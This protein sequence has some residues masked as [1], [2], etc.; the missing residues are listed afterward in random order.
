MSNSRSTIDYTEVRL[1]VHLLGPEDN[2]KPSLMDYRDIHRV[3][4]GRLSAPAEH[5]RTHPFPL[6]V[7]H[8]GMDGHYIIRYPPRSL[9]QP[10]LSSAPPYRIMS[11]SPPPADLPPPQ[12]GLPPTL[13]SVS[14]GSVLA[15]LAELNVKVSIED[16]LKAIHDQESARLTA[17]LRS[18]VT[19]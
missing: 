10:L 1:P 9:L 12:A 7:G 19:T 16:L 15:A 2:P 17:Q 6:T 13:D 3:A 11:P 4:R 18:V 8:V 5:G 14:I